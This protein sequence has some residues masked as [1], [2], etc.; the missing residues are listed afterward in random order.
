MPDT[1]TPPPK[2]SPVELIKESSRHL[3]GTLAEELA[4]DI[5]HFNDADKHLIKFHGTYQ[6]DDRDA[7]KARRKEGWAS[8]TSSWS[9]ARSPAARSPPTS[10]SPSTTSPTSTPTARCASPPARASSSTASLKKDLKATIAGINDTLLTT[11]GA[12]GDV[13]RNVMACPAPIA[14]PSTHEMQATRRPPSPPTSRRAAGAYHE[15]WLD[16]ESGRGAEQPE[17][18]PIYGKVYLPRKFKI[19]LAPAR[20]QLRRRLR[21]GSRLPRASSRTASVVGYNVLVGG[22][23]GMTHGNAKTFPHLGQPICYVSGRARWSQACRGGRQAVPRP[24]QPRRPQACPHQ[25]R[26][27]RLGRREVPRGA[28]DVSAVPADA[29]ARPE[30]HRRSTCTSAGTRRATASWFYGVSVENGRIKDEGTLRPA[31]RCAR[32]CRSIQPT[33]PPDAD[34]GHSAV[35]PA[36]VRDRPTSSSAD[37]HGVIPPERSRRCSS[38]AWPARRSRRAAWRS[39]SPS[40]AAGGD[41]RAGSGTQAAGAGA[42]RRSACA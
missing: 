28:G 22:G 23:M 5:D 2:R 12:C 29:A 41:R 35:R 38:T 19:G 4:A 1:P 25:V 27:P 18:E 6:Q 34:A 42:R 17:I 3:R 36:G 14:R 24:R 21:P 39:P 33:H 11:L 31:R 16:G 37:E 26:R 10:T 9:A 20:G 15:I 40:G 13:N 8:T 32:S 30:G 7:R